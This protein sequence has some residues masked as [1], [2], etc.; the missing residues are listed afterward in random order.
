MI[1]VWEKSL[2]T[3][4]RMQK[5]NIQMRTSSLRLSVQLLKSKRTRCKELMIMGNKK[6]KAIF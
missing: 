5:A 1:Y 6:G 4:F 2:L 3:N